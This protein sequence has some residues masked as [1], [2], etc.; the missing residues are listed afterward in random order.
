MHEHGKSDGPVIPAS[1]PNNAGRPAAEAGEGR[2]PAE[3]N[4]ERPTRPGPSA[5]QGVSRGLDRVREVARRDKKVRFTVLITSI[6][7]QANT[8]SKLAVNF[9]SRSRIKKRNDRACSPR[10]PARLRATWVQRSRS[11][12]R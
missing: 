8:S 2:G 9:A 10:S 5:G 1:L 7:S 4:T 11:D 3:G 6:P 12:D